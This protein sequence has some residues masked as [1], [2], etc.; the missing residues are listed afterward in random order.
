MPL[1]DRQGPLDELLHLSLAGALVELPDDRQ[2][3]VK[4]LAERIQSDMDKGV[5]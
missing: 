1:L 3:K 5:A 2:N 4:A